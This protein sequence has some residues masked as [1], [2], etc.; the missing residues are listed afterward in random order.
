MSTKKPADPEFEVVC[1]FSIAL[2]PLFQNIVLYTFD[3]TIKAVIDEATYIGIWVRVRV[4]FF[5]KM[6]T[7][8]VVQKAVAEN[9]EKKIEL[10]EMNLQIDTVKIENG[11]E[12]IFK[13][14]QL[15]QQD[16]V[17]SPIPS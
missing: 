1:I 5:K 10:Q 15:A 4:D 17:K 14:Q 11:V 8:P 2:Y 9:F 13:G 3:P 7:N 16:T 6:F 12:L